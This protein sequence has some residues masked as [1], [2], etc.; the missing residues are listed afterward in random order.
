MKRQSFKFIIYC[1]LLSLLSACSFSGMGGTKQQTLSQNDRPVLRSLSLLTTSP[2]IKAMVEEL[3]GDHQ[4]TSLAFSEDQIM[5]LRPDPKDVN[6]GE[7]QAFFYLG[8][9][10][11]PFIKETLVSI[12]K[13]RLNV[14]NLSRGMDILRHRVNNLDQENY[15]YLMNST[16]YKI[17]LNTIKNML[18][19]LDPGRRITYDEAFLA[20]SKRI[21]F[22]QKQVKEFMAE[23]PKL[24]FVVD[25]DYT[26]YLVRD[27]GRSPEG[28]A[29]YVA[30]AERFNIPL[31]NSMTSQATSVPAPT[32]RV[33]LYINEESLSRFADDI[34][35][36]NLIPVKIEL[37]K[38]GETVLNQLLEIFEE[39]RSAVN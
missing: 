14:V 33:F 18:Q 13:N 29:E 10:Y 8:A 2:M 30:K 12:D 5:N 25:S 31:P 23:N 26:A 19:E 3:G 15:Y 27:Y 7:Y 17:A 6:G 9:G 34:V 28:I 37:Y 21:D 16:N 36:F 22:Y 1:L 35:A 11:E 32:A 4:V 20:K 24:E 39:I 38:D